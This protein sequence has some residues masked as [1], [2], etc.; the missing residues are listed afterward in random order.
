MDD[1]LLQAQTFCGTDTDLF[2]IRPGLAISHEYQEPG[3]SV[4]NLVPKTTSSP[5]LDQVLYIGCLPT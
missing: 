4:G 2:T 3:L 1:K 5:F